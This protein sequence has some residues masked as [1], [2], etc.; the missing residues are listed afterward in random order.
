[1]RREYSIEGM[2]G[3]MVQLYEYLLAGKRVACGRLAGGDIL[4][5]TSLFCGSLA[6]SS[7]IRGE[8]SVLHIINRYDETDYHIPVEQED[9]R[10]SGGEDSRTV[11]VLVPNKC[12]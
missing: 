6:C 9:F 4:V 8:P 12:K 10:T 2:V 7:L 5:I 3:R 1:M 11:A